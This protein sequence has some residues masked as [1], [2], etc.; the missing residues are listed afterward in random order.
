MDTLNLVLL[1][2]AAGSLYAVNRPVLSDRAVTC[3]ADS[4]IR[5]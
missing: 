2:V 5:E 4:F 1:Y 3:F